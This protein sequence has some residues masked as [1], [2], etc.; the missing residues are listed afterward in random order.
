MFKTLLHSLTGMGVQSHFR[1]ETRTPPQLRARGVSLR[2]HG[3]RTVA[4]LSTNL[5]LLPTLSIRL[6]RQPYQL[7]LEVP[8]QCT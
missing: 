6:L 3:K 7:G 8:S 4:L 5:E 1:T 2:P